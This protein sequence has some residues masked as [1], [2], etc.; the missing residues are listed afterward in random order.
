MSFQG[1]SNQ[2]RQWFPGHSLIAF[3]IPGIILVGVILLALLVIA[4]PVLRNPEY[5]VSAAADPAVFQA[6]LVTFLAGFCAVGILA[7]TG[8]PLAYALSRSEAPWKGLVET[9]VDIPLVLPHTVAGLMVYLLF[10]SRGML[11]APLGEL[12]ITFEDAFPGIVAAMVFVAI[13]YYVNAVREGF[14]R[15]P[16]QLE[17]VARSLG[18]TRARMF[19]S[20]TLPLATR[21]ILYGALLAWGR[22][23]GE[24][25][26]VIMIAYFPMV[27][28]TL[29]YYRFNTGGIAE[30]QA[31]AFLLIL[32]CLVLFFLFRFL[33]RHAGVYDDRS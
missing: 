25:A 1:R 23:I 2:K 3:W 28:S 15:V 19:W 29:I 5:L 30:S 14:G 26:A 31:I 32:L 10:M 17:N 12:G 6:F 22:A 18:A 20:V 8:T 27:I 33:T 13:P 16:V 24:F 4:I 9:L 21:H 11:G 7:I